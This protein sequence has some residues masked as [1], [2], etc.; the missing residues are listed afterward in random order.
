[1]VAPTAQIPHNP[2]YSTSSTSQSGSPTAPEAGDEALSPIYQTK[3]QHEQSLFRIQW[4]GSRVV[5]DGTRA[6]TYENRLGC[7]IGG[8]LEDASLGYNQLG[9]F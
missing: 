7:R 1:M 2:N 5:A 6:P 4:W 8:V 3:L 9:V